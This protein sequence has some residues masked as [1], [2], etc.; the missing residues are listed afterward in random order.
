MRKLLRR[1]HGNAM[2]EMSLILPLLVLMLLAVVDVGLLLEQVMVVHDAARAGAAFAV[3]WAN[4]TNTAGMAAVAAQSASAIPG[5][6][7]SAINVCTCSPGGAPTSCSNRCAGGNP[8]AEYA[9]VTVTAG[10][11][12]LFGVQG[13]PARIPVSSTARMR[14]AWPGPN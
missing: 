7:A 10:I 3:P 2:I 5:A 1:Q 4:A 11:P 14:T 8:P 6:A 9:Q 13:L 12:L